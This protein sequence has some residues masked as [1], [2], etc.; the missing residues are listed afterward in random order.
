[1]ISSDF[2]IRSSIAQKAI[3]FGT[4]IESKLKISRNWQDIPFF[5]MFIPMLIFLQPTPNFISLSII[6]YHLQDVNVYIHFCTSNSSL[7]TIS[8]YSWWKK[9][10]KKMKMREKVK[11][12]YCSP[13]N[14]LQHELDHLYT[15]S[16]L[17]T[18]LRKIKSECITKGK[19][20]QKQLK[21]DR[22]LERIRGCTFIM[23]E[24][25]VIHF[26]NCRQRFCKSYKY[27]VFVF[28]FSFILYRE[29]N[30]NSNNMWL[31]TNIDIH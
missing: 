14:C 1:M 3:I 6:S 2:L 28:V 23:S 15:S 7:L 10:K 12:W 9:L 25:L 22:T 31:A 17:S 8:I 29:I 19:Q 27:L 30:S 26:I 20:F 18:I 16:N 5:K 4:L 24:I 11:L 21:W 13:W